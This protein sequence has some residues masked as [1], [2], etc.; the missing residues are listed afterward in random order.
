MDKLSRIQFDNSDCFFTDP[1]NEALLEDTLPLDDE[2]SC[3]KTWDRHPWLKVGKTGEEGDDDADV[4]SVVL[5]L[6]EETG[7]IFLAWWK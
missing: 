2:R 4:G 1:Y 7:G 6:M 3:W 5:K